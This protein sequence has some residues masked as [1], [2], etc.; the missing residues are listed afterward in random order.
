VSKKFEELPTCPKP[1]ERDT[2]FDVGLTLCSRHSDITG[3]CPTLAQLLSALKEK[4]KEEYPEQRIPTDWPLKWADTIWF[5]VIPFD[6]GSSEIDVRAYLEE[7]DES[8]STRWTSYEKELA[9]YNSELDAYQEAR[10]EEYRR[11]DAQRRL[12]A[13]PGKRRSLQNQIEALQ[14]RVLEIDEQL[15]TREVLE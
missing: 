9:E 6:E 7:S 15:S 4:I 13:L 1:P 10:S 14:A 8:F 2:L 5:S 3:S 12:A 11:G